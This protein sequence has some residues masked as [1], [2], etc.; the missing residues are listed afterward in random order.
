MPANGRRDIIRRL[1]G[2]SVYGQHSGY[3]GLEHLNCRIRTER[4]SV[5]WEV[6]TELEMNMCRQ[7][8]YCHALRV[9]TLLH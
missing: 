4:N 8:G 9:P 1:K 5:C 2:Y 6:L 7:V 3:A